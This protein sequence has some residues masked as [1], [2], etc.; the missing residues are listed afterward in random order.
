MERNKTFYLFPSK[1]RM[2][3][4][5]KCKRARSQRPNPI[6]EEEILP[7]YCMCRLQ[8]LGRMIKCSLCGESFIESTLDGIVESLSSIMIS[9][10]YNNV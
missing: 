5:P 6:Q 10:L 1:G 2:T 9:I 8:S 7:V 3:V 4:F